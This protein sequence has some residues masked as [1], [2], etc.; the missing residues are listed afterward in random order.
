[1]TCTMKLYH[2]YSLVKT[3]YHSISFTNRFIFKQK[4]LDKGIYQ[5]DNG[6]ELTGFCALKNQ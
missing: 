4:P 5:A 1:M 2:V 3:T 6:I